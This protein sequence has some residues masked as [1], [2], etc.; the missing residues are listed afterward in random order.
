MRG[1]DGAPLGTPGKTVPSS[2]P[3]H[4]LRD[5]SGD[6]A[7]HRDGSDARLTQPFGGY[8][9]T[10]GASP[11]APAQRQTSDEDTT[12]VAVASPGPYSQATKWIGGGA[13]R[14]PAV[15]SY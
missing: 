6:L 3:G 10:V 5:M 11:D 9:Q 13:V 4:R 8:P 12:G 2:A 14:D 15:G 7:R 1:P